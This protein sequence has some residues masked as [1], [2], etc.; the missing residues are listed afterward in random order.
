MDGK[1]TKL[2]PEAAQPSP[3]DGGEDQLE[4]QLIIKEITIDGIC[5]VY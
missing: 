2:E 4:E 3:H 1:A 5:G